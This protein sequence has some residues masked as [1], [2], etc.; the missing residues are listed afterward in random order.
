MSIN[1][2]PPR[3]T[4]D[5]HNEE[6]VGQATNILTAKLLKGGIENNKNSVFSPIG[7]ATILAILGDGASDDTNHDIIAL[8]KHPKDRA[9]VR[10][11][12]RSALTHLQG[13]DP[14]TAPQFRS[15]FYIYKN[16]SVDESYRRILVDDYF[17]TVRDVEPYNPDEFLFAAPPSDHKTLA[18]DEGELYDVQLKSNVQSIVNN[19]KDIVEFDSFKKE[20]EPIDETRIDTQK[21]AS[22]F[23]EVVEDRQYVE[24]PVIKD[25]MKAEP[26]VLVNSVD[27]NKPAD[28]L[29][30]AS[31][32]A[33]PERIKLPLRHYE[34]MEIMRAEESRYGKSVMFI[35][36]FFFSTRFSFIH[37]FTLKF[38]DKSGDGASIISGNSIVGEKE[39]ASENDTEKYEPKMLLFNGL[40][41]RGNW[42]TPFQV[43]CVLFFLIIACIIRLLLILCVPN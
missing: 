10:A 15:W 21:D 29:T 39:N 38:G 2:S 22:K 20:S 36:S 34:E 3:D 25:N 35:I 42:A 8:L 4:F 23:D 13:T 7:F 24:V 11:A 27:G 1:S 17:V 32:A 16:N 6:I 40:Y 33:E 5:D 14:Q 18:H 30:A 31:D 37:I 9:T 43:S 26:A 19:S 41:Y 28:Q 12:Y